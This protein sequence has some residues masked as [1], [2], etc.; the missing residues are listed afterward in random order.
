MDIE[1]ER[2]FASERVELYR[3]RYRQFGDVCF[4]VQIALRWER[5]LRVEP[6]DKIALREIS[7]EA[8][9]RQREFDV[10]FF[11]FCNHMKAVV[12]GV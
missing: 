7:G 1:D 2:R 8:K 12:E 4:P 10:A 11:T 6:V 3:A 5:A 9:G